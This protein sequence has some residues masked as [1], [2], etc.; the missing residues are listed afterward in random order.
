MRI[1]VGLRMGMRMK[2]DKEGGDEDWS[3]GCC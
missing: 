2:D 3:G 1:W